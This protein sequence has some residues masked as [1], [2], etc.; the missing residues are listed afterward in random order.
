MSLL[1]AIITSHF[2]IGSMV[3]VAALAILRKS[4]I[5]LLGW[6]RGGR[7][8]N[9]MDGHSLLFLDRVLSGLAFFLIP[10]LPLVVSSSWLFGRGAYNALTNSLVDKSLCQ[11]LGTVEGARVG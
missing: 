10:Q 8:G 9:G 2:S 4:P 6:C 7:G 3:V 11:T 5:I 1:V